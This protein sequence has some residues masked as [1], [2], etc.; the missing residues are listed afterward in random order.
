MSLGCSNSFS[1]WSIDFHPEEYTHSH[2]AKRRV[3]YASDG[4]LFKVT[5][6]FP[7]Y[8]EE[9]KEQEEPQEETLTAV[10]EEERAE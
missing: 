2:E 10:L 7:E 3:R 8:Q 5:L 6:Y 4:D 9:M 1:L